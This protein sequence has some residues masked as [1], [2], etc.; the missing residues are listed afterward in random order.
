MG[1][2]YSIAPGSLADPGTAGGPGFALSRPEW[3]AIQTYVTNALA[4]PTTRDAFS[5]SLGSGA[6]A[7]LKDFDQLIAAY[8]SMNGHVTTWQKTVFPATVSL[9]SD[10]YDYGANKAPVFF[11]PILT[12]AAILRDNPNDAGAKD[13]LKAILDNLKRDADTRAQKASTVAQQVQQFADD[14]AADRVTLV[15]ADG[16]GGLVKYYDNAYGAAS[17]EVAT[18]TKD[19][20]AQRLV[21]DGANAEYNHDVVVAA[22]TPTYAWVWPVGTIAAAIVAGVYGKKAVDALDRAHAAQDKIN[23]LAGRLAA[24]A[25]LM[26]AIH[27]AELGMNSITRDLS[28][29]LPVIQKVQGVWHGLSA[30]L[31]SI[32]HLIDADIREVPPIIMGLGV[33]EATKA[34]HNVSLAANTYRLN[35][36]VSDAGGPAGSMAAWKVATQFA[37]SASAA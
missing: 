14:S 24:D 21:L 23:N 13:A 17:A 27:S 5:K 15:G 1:N 37:S 32:S 2:V 30:D 9:A 7:D 33:D 16:A 12:E 22:T 3:I 8:Q 25:N 35:A 26:S 11:P 28:A 18:L 6:P 20:T 19:I 10:V 29:A 31:G 36:Y 34:W 4:L